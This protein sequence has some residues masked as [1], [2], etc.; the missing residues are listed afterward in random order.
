MNRFQKDPSNWVLADKHFRFHI[1]I[2]RRSMLLNLSRNRNDWKNKGTM[3]PFWFAYEVFAQF[4]I[5]AGHHVIQ[6]SAIPSGIVNFNIFSGMSILSLFLYS[7]VS[8]NINRSRWWEAKTQCTFFYPFF[9]I[10]TTKGTF[11]NTWYL[12]YWHDEICL[13][14][15]TNSWTRRCDCI[16]YSP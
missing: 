10:A 6:Y 3:Q 15:S 16:R 1:K 14:R 12:N 13:S 11:V 4:D 5:D 8:E 9:F 7:Y 2:I